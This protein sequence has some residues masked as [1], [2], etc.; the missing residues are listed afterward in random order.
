MI[1]PL[2]LLFFLLMLFSAFFSSAE[3][4]LLRTSRTRLAHKAKKDKRARILN[5]FL[6]KPEELFSLIL[7]GNNLV[8]VAAATLATHI[9]TIQFGSSSSFVLISE[10]LV[11]TILLLLLGEITPKSY[12]YHH[13]ERISLFYALP[14]KVISI[15]LFPFVRLTST[16]SRLIIR[17]KGGSTKKEFSMEEIKHFLSH[18]SQL[19]QHNPE[20]LRMVNEIIEISSKDL[21][22]IM[23][24]RPNIIALEENAGFAEL[25]QIMLS[26][27]ISKVPIYRRTL[28]QITGVIHPHSILPALMQ[29]DPSKITLNQIASPPVFVSEYSSLH[30]ALHEFKK[31]KI[32]LVIV[33]NEYG[34]TI[35]LLT[36]S[37]ILKEVVGDIE[38]R[39][40][41]NILKVKKN[42]FVIK[43]AL[44]VREVNQELEWE[45]PEKKDYTTMSG[46]F[47][48]L[49]GRLPVVKS[50][51]KI[52]PY[53]LI[54]RKLGIRRIDELTVIINE[55]DHD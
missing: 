46:L 11:T 26:R 8:N 19:F 29:N 31:S 16:I 15:I 4:S 41:Q 42:V 25:K 3:T 45:L 39:D 32:H 53:T 44:P 43:G 52:G 12:A 50:R 2:V 33:L 40:V 17:K 10:T 51:I 24:P 37:D 54:A 9:F 35:G 48:F 21:R 27:N 55:N 30:F 1:T 38:W 7:I 13:A 28:D 22:S 34:S 5:D 23:T 47:I 49:Y 18:E 14:L 36:P 20:T 6:K